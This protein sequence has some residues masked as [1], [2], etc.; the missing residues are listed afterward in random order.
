[1]GVNEGDPC[2]RWLRDVTPKKKKKKLFVLGPPPWM[3]DLDCCLVC[4]ISV[5][6]SVPCDVSHQM[7]AASSRPLKVT[8]CKRAKTA[9]Q[10]WPSYSTD[11]YN[12]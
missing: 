12:I 9:S 2:P 5:A 6:E 3:L 8:V 1:M 11:T 10:F 4:S 7:R